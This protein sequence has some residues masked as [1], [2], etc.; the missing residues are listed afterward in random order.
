MV[1]YPAMK[2]MV[3]VLLLLTSMLVNC[4]KTPLII[5]QPALNQAAFD[6][7]RTF[8]PACSAW[9]RPDTTT[10]LGRKFRT[11]DTAASG[12]LTL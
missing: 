2:V 5:M 7:K 3:Y 12:F 9:L 8:I 4:M 6:P 11:V 10:N 1:L